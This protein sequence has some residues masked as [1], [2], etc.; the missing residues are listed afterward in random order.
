MMMVLVNVLLRPLLLLIVLLV[1][2]DNCSIMKNWPTT[3]TTTTALAFV[4]LP[5]TT[6]SALCHRRHRYYQYPSSA[7]KTTTS[8]DATGDYGGDDDDDDDGSIVSNSNY[9]NKDYDKYST[10]FTSEPFYVYIEDTDAYGIMYNSNYLRAYERALFLQEQYCAAATASATSSGRN[11][12]RFDIDRDDTS[13]GTTTTTAWSIV[14]VGRQKFVS[15]PRLGDGLV[16]HGQLLATGTNNSILNDNDN[17]NREKEQQ[18]LLSYSSPWAV[19]DMQVTSPDGKVLYNQVNGLVVASTIALSP[20]TT[21]SSSFSSSSSLSSPVDDGSCSTAL[22]SSSTSSSSSSSPT[23]TTRTT[24]FR[25]STT[26]R[27]GRGTLATIQA[28]LPPYAIISR[29]EGIHG[30][31]VRSDDSSSSATSG[32]TKTSDT[33]MINSTSSSTSSSTYPIHRDELVQGDGTLLARLPL[34]TILNYFERGRTDAFG[35]PKNLHKLQRDHT[36]QAVVTSIRAL[37]LVWST[38]STDP[39]TVARTL[40]TEDG[41]GNGGEEEETEKRLTTTISSSSSSSWMTYPET[42]RLRAGETITVETTTTIKRKGMILEMDQKI[43][44][45]SRQKNSN[46]SSMTVVAQGMVTLMMIDTNTQRPTSKLPPWVQ[47][48]F[49]SSGSSNRTIQPSGSGGRRL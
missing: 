15:A 41:D 28:Y 43:L 20:T 48:M 42:D 21:T 32:S 44:R 39:G 46:P 34:R 23:T 3:T 49:G 6:S 35:G 13:T 27:M 40:S 8:I 33:T 45:R 11:D 29:S 4:I 1:V 36:L 31:K 37:S 25:A 30:V 17:H 19:W 26:A 10:N 9:N 47:A 16:I 14:A 5:P 7:T 18:L 38:H 12:D 22:V 24:T 2:I